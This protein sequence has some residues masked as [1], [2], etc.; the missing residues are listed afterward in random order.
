[1]KAKEREIIET[2]LGDASLEV[3]R[4]V[5]DAVGEDE[6]TAAVYHQYESIL[7]GAREAQATNQTISDAAITRVMGRLGECPD[8]ELAKGLSIR[9]RQG[10]SLRRFAAAAAILAIVAFAGLFWLSNSSGPAERVQVAE[11][12]GAPAH[13]VVA[14]A[15]EVGSSGFS[16]P[17]DTR[18]VDFGTSRSALG[19]QSAPFAS[20]KQGLLGTPEGGLLVIK[21]GRSSEILRIDKPVILMA[22]GG[23]VRIGP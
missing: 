15:V 3:Q 1:M 2:V 19:T 10:I 6:T 12:E 5:K 8:A 23:D 13:L 17:S 14:T 21:A 9:R 18:F 11:Q 22:I 20:L 4:R 7:T 16:F